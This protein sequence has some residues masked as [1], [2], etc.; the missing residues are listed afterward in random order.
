MP[1]DVEAPSCRGQA[2][3]GLFVL[4]V[5]CLDEATRDREDQGRCEPF[6]LDAFFSLAVV[7][8]GKQ[9]R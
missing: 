8:T 3:V 1:L 5:V 2:Y 4:G 9:L 6:T 7:E